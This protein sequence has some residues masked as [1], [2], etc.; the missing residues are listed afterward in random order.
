[1]LNADLGLLSVDHDGTISWDV[2]QAIKSRVWG[3]EVRAVEVY[4]A[5]CNVVN[6]RN[7]R[8]LWR[9][10][11]GE[12]CPDLL[13]QMLTDRSRWQDTLEARYYDAW[14]HAGAV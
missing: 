9:L 7:T 8:H 2:L 14:K 1:M 11:Q 5:D 3:P 10:G 12:F 13:G 6:S 4:P